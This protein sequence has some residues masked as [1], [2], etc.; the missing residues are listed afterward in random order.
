[1][2]DDDE[3]W[4][5]YTFEKELA[6]LRAKHA[7]P[8]EENAALI[9]D[10]LFE[11][12]DGD[13]NE[14]EFFTKSRP[15]S[16]N[17]PWLSKDHPETAEW[18]KGYQSTIEKLLQAAKKDKCRFPIGGDHTSCGL[19]A[20]RSI[21]M[22]R[23]TFLLL[24][25]A[26]NDIGDGRIDAGL[27][28]YLCIIRMAEHLYQQPAL[29]D[30]LLGVAIEALAIGQFK[31]FVVTGDATEEHLS[32]IE[33]ALRENQ[34]EW[35]SDVPRILEC[36]KLM[37]KNLWSFFYEVNPDGKTRFAR[38]QRAPFITDRQ[39]QLE[40]VRSQSFWR[41][42]LRK[43]GAIWAWFILPTT[44]Q[45]AAAIIDTAFKPLYEMAEPNFEWKKKPTELSLSSIKFNFGF[46]AKLMASLS[47]ES[48]YAFHDLYLRAGAELRGSQIIIALRRYKNE[49][50]RWPEGLDDVKGL[51]ASEVFVDPINGDSFVYKLTEENFTLYSKGKNNIDEKGERDKESGADDWLIWPTKS[52]KIREK[53]EDAE[54]Q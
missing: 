36:E 3:G 10:E 6:A 13:P 40:D 42:K 18:L 33:K 50:G 54:E 31:R 11:T 15:S 43:L 1:M 28:K 46:V 9:Y 5:P 21:K 26:N 44:P 17:E 4:R 29:I 12:M 52:R 24:S 48:Y 34:H 39:C 8:D 49:N 7:V 19:S 35:S 47:K 45:K 30:F 41:K 23:C 25:A 16:R 38:S 2:P 14:P 51:A 32:I 20:E 27:E 37:A 53:K 22:R